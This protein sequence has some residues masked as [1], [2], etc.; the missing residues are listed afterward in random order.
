MA[1]QPA[2]AAGKE[3][4]PATHEPESK[5]KS[6]A[7]DMGPEMAGDEEDA[8]EDSEEKPEKDKEP[9]SKKASKKPEPAEEDDDNGEEEEDD[10]DGKEEADEPAK[11]PKHEKITERHEKIT[12]RKASQATSAAD[13][14]QI[15]T[16]CQIAGKPELAAEFITKNFSVKQVQEKLVDLRAEASTTHQVSNR[17]GIASAN[18][19]NA[20]IANASQE[21]ERKGTS[22]AVEIAKAIEANPKA[23]SAYK[24]TLP[25]F[26]QGITGA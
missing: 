20:L 11:P 9:E 23:Y 17:V 12:E 16:L 14:K 2:I 22:K 10:E 6:K 24:R 13:L 8:E 15:A 4:D 1:K 18:S 19:M 21:A 5:K 26:D 7:D 25:G 3:K